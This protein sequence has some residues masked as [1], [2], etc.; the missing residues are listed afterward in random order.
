MN[1]K[2]IFRKL[3]REICV[4]MSKLAL[5]TIKIKYE[6][7]KFIIPIHQGIGSFHFFPDFTLWMK[8]CLKVNINIHKNKPVI[9]CGANIGQFMLNLKSLDDKMIYYGFEPNPTC[10]YYIYELIRHNNF[11]ETYLFSYALSDENKISYLHSNTRIS[12]TS[13]FLKEGTTFK[14]KF[15][16]N[17]TCLQ[18]DFFL[19]NIQKI[20]AGLIKIDVEGFEL[21]V[22]SGLKNYLS[23]HSPLLV[24]EILIEKNINEYK[25]NRIKKL[26]EL[27]SNLKYLVFTPNK[28]NKPKLLKNVNELLSE[29][30]NDFLFVKENLADKII[31]EFDKL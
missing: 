16:T 30:I 12:G 29:E 23:H 15:S 22:L 3:Y 1:R 7:K 27:M 13:S 9:D 24:V 4:G 14:E 26:Y 5:K 6:N 25:K 11:K 8:N 17:V 10:I 2:S 21:E 18:G 31:A 28:Y 20:D 19:E